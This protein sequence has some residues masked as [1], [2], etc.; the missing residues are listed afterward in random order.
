[1][2]TLNRRITT[3]FFQDAGGY[4]ALVRRWSAL[5]RDRE[6]RKRLTCAHHLLYCILRGRNWQAA[7]TPP[8]NRRKLDNGALEGWSGRRALTTIAQWSDTTD[9]LAPFSGLLRNDAL[10]RI[11][12]V[13]TPFRW[14]ED[15]LGK[16]PYAG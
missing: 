14:N 2:K 16:E 15:I 8:T 11:R 4:D 12:A 3:E 5:M 10:V 1:M 13:V 7:L 6:Q 9:L